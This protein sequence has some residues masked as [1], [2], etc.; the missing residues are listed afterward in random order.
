MENVQLIYETMEGKTL[1]P[2]LNSYL[3]LKE[4]ILRSHSHYKSVKSY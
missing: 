1:G 3:E 2:I 4:G